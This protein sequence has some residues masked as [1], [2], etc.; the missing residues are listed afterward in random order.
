MTNS[1]PVTFNEI[2]NE[3]AWKYHRGQIADKRYKQFIRED[4]DEIFLT[5]TNEL[6]EVEFGRNFFDKLELKL[7]DDFRIIME[8][9]L[10]KFNYQEMNF[11]Q[12]YYYLFHIRFWDKLF[13][14]LLGGYKRDE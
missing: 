12:R 11:F 13:M 7:Q 10:S 14:N 6:K 4:Y 9:E 5:L 3:T 8:L 1:E 2:F